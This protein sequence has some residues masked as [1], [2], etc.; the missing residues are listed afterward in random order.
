M[1][2]ILRNFRTNQT[3]ILLRLLAFVLLFVAVFAQ[4]PVSNV[5]AAG[6]DLTLTK[7]IE[8]G[9]TTAQ[10]GDVIRYRIH[11]ACSNL[12]TPCGPMEI[13][14]VLQA[15]LIYQ[16]PP[17]SSVP[18]GFSISYAPGTRTITI[19]KDD[20][21]LLDGSQYDA[22]IAVQVDYDLRPLPA[23]INNTVNGRIAPTG[24]GNWENTTPA[25]A[26]PITIGTANPHWGM[27]K[28][29][30]SPIINP[31][32]DTDVTYQIQ[33]CPTP[34]PPGEGNVPLRN[35]TITD[36][37]PTG[38]TFVSASNGGTELARHSHMAGLRG[39]DLSSKLPDALCDHPLQQ[40]DF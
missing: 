20:N 16:P 15:G 14:D 26:P 9:V 30:S 2:I 28:T 5:R 10:V 6:T 4:A 12:T 7:T 22:V 37:L 33:L 24:P 8:G 38:A 40:C 31:T 39:T 1:Q 17:T 34:P 11:F 19:T 21:N 36:I 32:V 18:A 27:T 3:P 29:L 35:I 25:S 23:T 13:T